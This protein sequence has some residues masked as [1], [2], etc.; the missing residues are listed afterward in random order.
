LAIDFSAVTFMDS[1]GL[2]VLASAISERGDGSR[3]RVRGA[4][5]LVRRLL[6][7]SG[8]DTLLAIDSECGPNSA[9]PQPNAA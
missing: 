6:T 2:S 7:M 3:I 1:S 4:S 9:G 8:L 5:K